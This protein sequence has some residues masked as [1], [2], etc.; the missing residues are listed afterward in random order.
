MFWTLFVFG[1]VKL[2]ENSLSD[3]Q[4]TT[5]CCG[6]HSMGL[7]F[8]VSE[9]SL[10]NKNK[11]RKIMVA[12]FETI[13]RSVLP[14]PSNKPRRSKFWEERK[15]NGEK[16]SI[17]GVGFTRWWSRNGHYNS[18]RISRR[19]RVLIFKDHQLGRIGTVGKVTNLRLWTHHI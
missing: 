7:Y 13:S 16:W 1:R 4:L 19:T 8:V 12:W 9:N 2:N 6:L 17:A 18:S 5:K 3:V 14:N 15:I 10:Q 11:Y